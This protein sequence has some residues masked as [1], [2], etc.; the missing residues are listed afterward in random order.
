[1]PDDLF[2]CRPFYIPEDPDFGWSWHLTKAV[3]KAFCCVSFDTLRFNHPHEYPTDI[4]PYLFHNVKV[5]MQDIVLGQQAHA[6][7]LAQCARCSYDNSLQFR[8]VPA[9]WLQEKIDRERAKIVESA[10]VAAGVFIEREKP[11]RGRGC[12][13]ALRRVASA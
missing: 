4:N 8:D 6:V 3:L 1:M 12:V 9:H 13:L 11:V 2:A 7:V 5:L 10:F